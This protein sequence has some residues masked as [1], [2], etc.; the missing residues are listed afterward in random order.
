MNVTTVKNFAELDFELKLFLTL[1]SMSDEL[2]GIRTN[3]SALGAYLHKSRETVGA[4]INKLAKCNI[5]KYKYSG[6]CRINPDF[7]F[8]GPKERFEEAKNLY[9]AFNSDVI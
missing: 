1:L 8:A 3:K 7:Y 9:T 4:H 2:G 6:L 5:I